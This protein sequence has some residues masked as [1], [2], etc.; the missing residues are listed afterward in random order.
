MPTFLD[1][2]DFTKY[3]AR[4]LVTHKLASAP[5]SPV[6]GQRYYDTTLNKEGVYN[7]ATWDYA[8]SG[9]ITSVAGTS[10]ITSSGG[11]APTIAISPASGSTAGSMSVSDFNKLAAA[12]ASNT[13]S[14]IV[15]RDASGNVA[16][17]TATGAL[18]GT[19]SNASNLN[20][21]TPAFYLGRVNHTGTQLSSTISDFNTQVNVAIDT[22]VVARKYSQTI[23]DGSATAITVTH[24]LNNLGPIWGCSQVASPFTSVTPT[25]TFPTANTA[26]FTFAVAPTVNQY[27]VTLIG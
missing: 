23:G 18:T 4:N 6:A 3:E 12:T 24:N 17:T 10:P 16:F 13:A 2:V 1:H 19:A 27:R 9:G 11:S 14:T 21:Q 26:V 7:G 25:V 5:V 22:T 15:L 20:N 8:G